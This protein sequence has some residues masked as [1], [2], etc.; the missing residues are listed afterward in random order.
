[1]WANKNNQHYS[2]YHLE[3]SLMRR[4]SV[5]RRRACG[6]IKT[7]NIIVVITSNTP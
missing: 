1:M 4:R 2:S 6:P 5:A 3:Y 7:I